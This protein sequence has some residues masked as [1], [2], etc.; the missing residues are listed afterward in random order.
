[1]EERNS[2]FYRLNHPF[3]ALSNLVDMHYFHHYSTFF[4]NLHSE[5]HRFDAAREVHKKLSEFLGGKKFFF[6]AGPSE[7]EEF[8]NEEDKERA[9]EED[10]KDAN[11]TSLDIIAY[12]YLKE[13]LHNASE[14]EETKYME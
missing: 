8:K 13:E 14:T 2:V 12:A 1:L 3:T 10:L 7:E 4:C 6:Q 9:V 11:L 5:M